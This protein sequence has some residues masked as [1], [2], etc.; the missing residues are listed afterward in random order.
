MRKKQ[1]ELI[2][3]LYM[4][5]HKVTADN[6]AKVL[7]L[8]VRTIKS[9][10]AEI[11]MSYTHL[12][13]SSNRGYTINKKKAKFLLQCNHDIPQDYEGRYIYIVKKCF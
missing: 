6:L 4:S 13:S 7:N 2:N 10:I 12:I 11:N 9:Y 3:Y 8:S 1:Q 5:N